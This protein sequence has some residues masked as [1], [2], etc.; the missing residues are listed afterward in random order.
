MDFNEIV[1]LTDGFFL[2]FLT[3]SGSYIAETLGC[4]TQLLFSKNLYF[5]QFIVF[6]LLFFTISLTTSENVSPKKTFLKSSL[7]WVFFLL[8]TKMSVK[9][10]IAVIILLI[11]LF[12][13]EKQKIY[14]VNTSNNENN[15]QNK[16]SNL[17]IK[18]LINYQKILLSLSLI[19]TIIGFTS[20]Y[21]N[22]K[23]EYK[24]RFKISKFLFGFHKCKSM[25]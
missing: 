8:F 23:H 19:L 12:I 1:Q 16:N 3:I 2:L 13:I 15:N 6:L 14:I 24:S 9:F 7:L 22:K 10:T 18:T 17:Q 5:K 20:Y 11:I 25:K 4:E 21:F